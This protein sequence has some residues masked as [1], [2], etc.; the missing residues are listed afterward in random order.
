MERELDPNGN[1]IRTYIDEEGNERVSENDTRFFGHINPLNTTQNSFLSPYGNLSFGDDLLSTLKSEIGLL[2]LSEGATLTLGMSQDQQDKIS[3]QRMKQM[4]FSSLKN[5][6]S[7][8]GPGQ[9]EYTDLRIGPSLESCYYASIIPI[10]F[11]NLV[12]LNSRFGYFID[13][14][15]VALAG[16]KTEQDINRDE[17]TAEGESYRFIK[18]CLDQSHGYGTKIIRHRVTNSPYSNNTLGTPLYSLKDSNQ[19]GKVIFDN[20]PIRTLAGANVATL[21]TSRFAYSEEGWTKILELNDYDLFAKHNS[22]TRENYL[23]KY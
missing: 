20:N 18:S 15:R 16:K 4:V 7:F 17:F 10:N 12:K 3:Y 23:S 1:P 2:K 13:F 6:G 8:I 21:T 14:H 19:V 22:L 11:E 9:E 5:N